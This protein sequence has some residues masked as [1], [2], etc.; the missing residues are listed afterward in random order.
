MRLVL[1]G[2][3]RSV[4]RRVRRVDHDV[5]RSVRADSHTL[6]APPYGLVVA[7]GS[8]ARDH[9]VSILGDIAKYL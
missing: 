9:L 6:A 5:T 8:F 2:V 7:S 1:V 4:R 3:T